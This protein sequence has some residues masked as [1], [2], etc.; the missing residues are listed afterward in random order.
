M[1]YYDTYTTGG[2]AGLRERV[3]A[4]RVSVDYTAFGTD[5]PGEY[6]RDEWVAEVGRLLGLF[7]ATQHVVG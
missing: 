2:E 3:F 1:H 5:A 4:E 6:G 7:E